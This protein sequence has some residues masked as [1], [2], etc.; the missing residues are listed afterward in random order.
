MTTVSRLGPAV[1]A[2]LDAVIVG[3]DHTDA[4]VSRADDV[5]ADDAGG[6]P[7]LFTELK[8]DPR[9]LGLETLLAEITKLTRVRAI[10]L[11]DGLFADVAD[12]RIARWRAR[13]IAEY[14]STLRRDHPREVASTLLAVLGRE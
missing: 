11:P 12:K 3:A 4:V 7:A 2:A 14:S 1:L 8:A 13:A 5:D 6:G 9:Q 10:G